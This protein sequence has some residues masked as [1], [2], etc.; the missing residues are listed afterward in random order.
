MELLG[1]LWNLLTSSLKVFFTALL[2]T[3]ILIWFYPQEME[4]TVG[5]AIRIVFVVALSGTLVN[6]GDFLRHRVPAWMSDRQRMKAELA[7]QN[8]DEEMT[9]SSIY[10]LNEL[11][12]Q[13]L[14]RAINSADDSGIFRKWTEFR[15]RHDDPTVVDMFKTFKERKI[16][17]PSSSAQ[18]NHSVH[19]VDF[20]KLSPIVLKRRADI[21]D[22]LQ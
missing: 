8:S 9:I 18:L 7:L 15:A 14:R 3:G 10:H 12:R 20:W 2:A 16:I 13:C 22:I 17:L 1:Y 11:E 4:G 19:V 21:I 6:V 5:T